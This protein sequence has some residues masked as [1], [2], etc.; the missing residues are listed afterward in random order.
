[1]SNRVLFVDDEP[2]ILLAFARQLRKFDVVAEL[3]LIPINWVWGDSGGSILRHTWTL[4][5]VFAADHG[6]VGQIRAQIRNP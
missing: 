3:P 5:D 2:N 4:G 6:I 1:M